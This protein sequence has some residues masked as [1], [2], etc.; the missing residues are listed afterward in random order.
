MSAWWIRAMAVTALLIAQPASAE[1]QVN[2]WSQLE[3]LERGELPALEIPGARYRVG[4]FAFDDPDATGLGE[5][6]ATLLAREILLNSGVRSIG[7]IRF[8]G[9]LSPSPVTQLSYFDR[10]DRVSEAQQVTLAVWGHIQR[11]DGRIRIDTYLQ[12]PPSTL[13]RA[14]TWK[15]RFTPE[16][17]VEQLV[18]RLR[19]DRLLLQSQA[20]SPSTADAIGDSARSMDRLRKFPRDDQ[21][22]DVVL[23]VGQVYWVEAREGDWIKLNAGAD[24]NGWVHS[25]GSCTGE[26][27]TVLEAAR[28]AG[29]LLRFMETPRRLPATRARLSQD[30]RALGE[31][32][33]ALEGLGDRSTEDVQARSLAVADR[34]IAASSTD[35]REPPGGAAFAN[36]R[37]LARVVIELKLSA[38]RGRPHLEPSTARDIAYEL[39]AAS[40]NDPANTEV[41]HNLSLLFDH[42][43]DRARADLARSLTVQ[44]VRP[45][46]APSPAVDPHTPDRRDP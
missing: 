12:L 13:E 18:A 5:H 34:W 43:G 33:S 32:L 25:S 9:G 16:T 37:A 22:P 4:V 26:C 23:P 45:P 42:A 29:D 17:R 6:V 14:F 28:F 38:R 24:V 35:R 7:V 30:A 31:Q 2:I 44:T 39:A 15:V 41:L 27:A 36:V 3:L 46:S 19:P 1:E 8:V 20:V 21:E 40:L 10:V 11:A